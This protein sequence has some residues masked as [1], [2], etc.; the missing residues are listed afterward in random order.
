MSEEERLAKRR[1]ELTKRWAWAFNAINEPIFILDPSHRIIDANRASQELFGVPIQEMI[2]KSC[3]EI[4]HQSPSPIPKC[5]L[6]RL[7]GSL[8]REEMEMELGSRRYNVTVEPIMDQ[9]GDLIGVVHISRDVTEK[10]LTLERLRES[11]ERYRLVTESTREIIITIDLEGRI[12]FANKAAL[13]FAG[14]QLKEA[15]GKSITEFLSEEE[16]TLF[17]ERIKERKRGDL[18]SYRYEVSAVNKRGDRIL[19]EAES[20]PIKRM[21]KVREILIVARDITERK[22]KERRLKESEERYR[23]LVENVSDLICTH[24]SKGTVLSVNRVALEI[25]GYKEDEIIGKNLRDFLAPDVRDEFD[26]YLEEILKKGKAEGIMKVVTKEGELRFWE[27]KNSLKRGEGKEPII[28]GYARDVTER[29]KAE[30]ALKESEEKYRLA[31]ENI[32]EVIS[33]IDRELKIKDVSPSVERMLGWKREE[34]VGRSIYEVLKILPEEYLQKALE[35]IKQILAG[36]RISASRYEFFTKDGEKRVGEISGSPWVVK[37]EVQG[38]LCVARDV[39]ERDRMEKE[40]QALREQLY[41]AQRLESIGRLAAGVA[42]DFNN[43]L[44]VMM[45]FTELLMREFPRD[46]RRRE[47]L[48]KVIEAGERGKHIIRQLL[49]FGRKQTLEPKVLDLNELIKNLTKMLHRLIGEDILMEMRLKE[50]ISHVYVDPVQMEQVILNI[51]INARD[52]MPNGGTLTIETSEVTLDEHYA[53]LHQGVTPGR[54]I[55]LAISDTGHGM[56][57]EVLSRIFEPFFTTKERGKGT[58]LGLSTVYG[59]LKQSGGNIWAYS[60]PGKGST[61]KIYL[62]VSKGESQKAS[63]REEEVA[64][65]AQGEKILVVEDDPAL[66]ELC[67]AILKEA[68][69]RVEKAGNGEEALGVVESGLMVPDLLITDLVMPEMGGEELYRVLKMR[70]P[71]LKVLFMS[72]YSEKTVGERLGLIKGMPFIQKPFSVN[73]LISQVKGLLRKADNLRKGRDL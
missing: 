70:F 42:H 5:P 39:T 61:F 58:G 63:V 19:V 43:M 36:G 65:R 44:G 16:L 21:G 69:F 15:L 4:V 29:L 30:R 1:N 18:E 41:R 47:K 68:G 8:K 50:G 71:Q 24:D 52:A 20:V 34:L 72:G 26:K 31:F 12:T 60:E 57:K 64:F 56:D 53:S 2:G 13:E 46:D 6:I 59:I 62:P 48:Q 23:D 40:A 10:I 73:A 28:R 49:A 66:R 22:E 25:G 3:C 27:Y 7:R 17:S 67:C 51:V 54:Y 35:E 45:G 38:V 37:G 55:L 14:Y 32:S 9:R 11:E 33:I